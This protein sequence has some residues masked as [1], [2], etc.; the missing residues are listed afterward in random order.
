MKVHVITDASGRI[1]GTARFHRPSGDGPGGP[2]IEPGE[3]AS[4][5]EVEL[6]SGLESEQDPEKLHAALAKHLT[7]SS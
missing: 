5:H 2:R 3:G 6:P 4:V 1:I 7:K